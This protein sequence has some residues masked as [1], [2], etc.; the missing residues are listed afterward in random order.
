MGGPIALNPKAHS[1]TA[2]T[3]TPVRGVALS[4]WECPRTTSVL[5][6]YAA[7]HG[8]TSAG[9]VDGPVPA[10]HLDPPAQKRDRNRLAAV[11]PCVLDGCRIPTRRGQWSSRDR[12][13]A[14]PRSADRI[15]R[16]GER[17]Q[18]S[19]RCHPV[20]DPGT[21]VHVRRHHQQRLQD[22][23]LPGPRCQ[24]VG[25]IGRRGCHSVAA[26][27]WR[28]DSPALWFRWLFLRQRRHAGGRLRLFHRGAVLGHL[29]SDRLRGGRRQS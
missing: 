14:K 24:S 15:Q 27:C 6:R 12:S 28:H 25:R 1:A 4:R 29:V 7:R 10:L 16:H 5:A 2:T 9:R 21:R 17:R 18:A 22:R 23:L 13:A 26:G 20:G 11:L 19:H 8:R 3:L